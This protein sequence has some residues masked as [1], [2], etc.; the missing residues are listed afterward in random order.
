MNLFPAQ[1]NA[2]CVLQIFL[3]EFVGLGYHLLFLYYREK[4][5][6]N[7][8]FAHHTRGEMKN[9]AVLRHYRVTWRT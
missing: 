9:I 7:G 6:F 5:F 1:G 4:A 8:G 3:D 2:V